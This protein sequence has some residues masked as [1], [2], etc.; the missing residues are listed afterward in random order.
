MAAPNAS[1]YPSLD[2]LLA[3]SP[4]LADALGGLKQAAPLESPVLLLGEP[5]SGRSTLARALHGASGRAGAL[6]ELDPSTVPA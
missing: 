5:G 4:A 1:P 2:E 3:A 6:V